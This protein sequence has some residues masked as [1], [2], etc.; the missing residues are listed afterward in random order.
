VTNTTFTSTLSKCI[1]TKSKSALMPCLE[2]LSNF[3]DTVRQLAL[4]KNTTPKDIL[5]A[6]DSLRDD[7]LVPLGVALDDQDGDF[8][9][10]PHLIDLLT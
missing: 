6:C 9:L 10:M 5:R 7:A 4:D 2:V 3:R 8:Y 1:L